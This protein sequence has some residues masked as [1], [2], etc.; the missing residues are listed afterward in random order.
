MVDPLLRAAKKMYKGSGAKAIKG[1]HRPEGAGNFDN[2]D[3][4]NIVNSIDVNEGTIQHTPTLDKHIVNKLY[5]DG[6]IVTHA[7]VNDAHHTKTVSSDI[8]HDDTSGVHQDV[9]TTASPSFV[10]VTAT[11]KMGINTAV[12]P[13]A[14]RL[15]IKASG[16]GVEVLRILDRDGRRKFHYY[17]DDTGGDLG[18][19]FTLFRGDGGS[20]AIIQFD[21]RGNVGRNSFI[22]NPNNNFGLDTSSPT[23]KFSLAEKGG[24]TPLGGFAIKLTNKTGANTVQGNLVRADTAVDDAFIL[25]AATDD[26]YLGVVLEAGVSD[27]S[28]AWIV[29]HGIADVLFDDNVA[30][31]RANWVGTGA[32]GLARTQAAPPALGV[33]AHF[34]E[35]GHS[36]ESVSATGGGTFILARVVLQHN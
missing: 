26:E 23:L 30:A 28:E 18:G 13:G 33:A 32:A 16:A 34:E 31:V 27:G 9:N 7:A 29:V 3:D 2:M 17:D 24:M 4:Y 22:N 5:V 36:I 6:E 15:T 1:M 35:V 8:V 11:S 10:N 20:A 14:A 25:T 12:D 19:E 21:S